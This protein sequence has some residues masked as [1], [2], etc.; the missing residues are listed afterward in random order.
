MVKAQPGSLNQVLL[1]LIINAA[2]AIEGKGRIGIST[3]EEGYNIVLRVTDNG[4]GIA[5]DVANRIFD[6]FFSTKDIGEG[7]GL[8]LAISHGIIK[9]LGGQIYVDS[10]EG[11]GTTFTVILP[12]VIGSE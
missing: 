11:E 3:E 4:C 1:N 9:D 2:Q 5:P 10:I 6:P 8:G 12:A 7:T